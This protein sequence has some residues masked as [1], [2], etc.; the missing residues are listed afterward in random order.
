MV[1]PLATVRLDAYDTLSVP[2]DALLNAPLIPQAEE[3]VSESSF[4]KA[5]LIVLLYMLIVPWLVSTPGPFNSELLN[6]KVIRLDK[7]VARLKVPALTDNVPDPVN[8][9]L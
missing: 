5:A 8:V 4:T 2:P 6:D 7:S 9:P 1:K 3:A